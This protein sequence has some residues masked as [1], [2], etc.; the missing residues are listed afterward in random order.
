MAKRFAAETA[1]WTA[2]K[3]VQIFG[4]N[5]YAKEYLVEGFF[6]D[7]KITEIYAGTSEIQRLVISR[8]LPTD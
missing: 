4:A 1:L 5:G 8:E 3:A 7:A 2:T 6:R